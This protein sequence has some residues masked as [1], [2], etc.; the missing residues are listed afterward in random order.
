VDGSEVMEVL[1]LLIRRCLAHGVQIFPYQ[2]NAV[3][4]VIDKYK[5]P[6]SV[7]NGL[8]KPQLINYVRGL[9][10][11]AQEEVRDWSE[12]HEIL[13]ALGFV[14]KERKEGHRAFESL[15]WES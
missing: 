10:L 15:V 9:Y 14:K 2:L 5:L 6:D 13:I 12:G 1:P 11:S 3:L 8:S 7:L 4:E